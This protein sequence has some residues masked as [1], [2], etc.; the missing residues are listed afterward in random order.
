M[1]ERDQV[2]DALQRIA[3]AALMY[4][5]EVHVDEP[6]Y[7]VQQDVDWCIEPL[8][9]LPE[10]ELAELRTSIGRVIT[11]PTAHREEVFRALLDL[12]PEEPETA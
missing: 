7:T 1:P 12:V 3:L 9:D 8:S 10:D 4:Y 5:P 11:N 2:D 6:S